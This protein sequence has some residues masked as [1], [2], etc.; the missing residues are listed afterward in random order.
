[1]TLRRPRRA[2]ALLNA[3][4]AC[5][6]RFWMARLHGPMTLERR[7]Q[8][9]QQA[10]RGVLASLGAK[11]NAEGDLPER[12]LVVANHLSYLDIVAFSAAMPCIFVAKAEV[13]S[14]PFFGSAARSGGTLFLDRA[15]LSSA[16]QVATKIGECLQMALPV[17]RPT[18]EDL[19]VGTP[20]LIFP[21]GTSTDGSR[22]K[23]FHSRL[24]DPATKIAAPVTAAAIRY[25]FEAEPD[26]I[27][28]ERDVCWYGDEKFLPHLWKVLGL[29]RFSANIHF[30]RPRIYADR[31]SAAEETHAEVEAMR[32]SAPPSLSR[33]EHPV[34]SDSGA[35]QCSGQ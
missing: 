23:R 8:W 31:R 18:D 22:V 32:E 4:I 12:G 11:W 19:S 7:A 26:G 21:E 25:C 3:L 33:L 6:I 29:R 20:V 16:H 13:A 28:S 15:S 1:M 24:I 9:L 10:S 35:W 2:V 17:L 14:W 30:G 34:P 27:L 5:V